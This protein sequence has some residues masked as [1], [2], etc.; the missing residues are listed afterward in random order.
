MGKIGKKVLEEFNKTRSS[1][2]Y[3]CYAPFTSMKISLDGRVSPC[4]YNRTLDDLYLSKSL[5][6]IWE[7]EIFDNYRRHIKNN[8]LPLA[9]ISC[10]NALLNGEYNSVKIHQYDGFKVSLVGKNRPRIIE[11]ALANTCNLECIMCTGRNS[12]SIRKNREKLP[13][14]A[15]IF[16]DKFRMELQEFI[17]YLQEAVF[18]GG[19]PFL[20][21]LYYDIWDDIMRINPKCKMSIV[22]NGTVLND[23][24]KELIKKGNFKINLSLDSVSKEIYEKIRVNANFEETLNNIKFFGDALKSK[25]ERL[26]IPVCP[27]KLNRFEIPDIVRFCNSSG[28]SLN[29]VKVFG[30]VRHA[31]WALSSSELAEI[32]DFYEKQV[33]VVKNRNDQENVNEFKDLIVRIKIWINQATDKENVIESYNLQQDEVEV[34]KQKFWNK[35]D[36]SLK[37]LYPDEKECYQVGLNVY[38]KFETAMSELPDYYESNHFFRQL[39]KI[40]SLSI[41]DVLI[42][43]HISSVVE[44]AQEIFFYSDISE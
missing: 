8:E 14:L 38:S 33:F 29:F 20:I 23:K 3:L 2:K 42:N 39:L 24:I 41:L 40:S 9:C 37:K 16:D 15:S 4:C 36:E 22:T 28:Y 27:L 7:G 13:A 18:A 34:L 11:L 12:S 19:E 1:Q 44:R 5:S 32:K 6:E 25:G 35:I 21:S 43:H 26:H 10:E 31:L 17:P 30:A